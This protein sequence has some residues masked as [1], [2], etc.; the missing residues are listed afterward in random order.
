MT[1]AFDALIVEIDMRHFNVRRQRVGFDCEAVIMR[2]DFDAAA[3]HFF[4]RL[5]TTPMTED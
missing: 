5:I 2:C 4:H 3:R 1:H